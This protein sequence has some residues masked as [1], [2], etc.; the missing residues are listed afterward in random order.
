MRSYS[1]KTKTI[2]ISLNRFF[3]YEP[4]STSSF[5]KNLNTLGA[6]HFQIAKRLQK[7]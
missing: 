5:S 7:I 6:I 1:L 2:I 3:R 4:L